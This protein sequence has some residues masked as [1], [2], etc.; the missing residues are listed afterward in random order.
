M[1]MAR[2]WRDFQ[3]KHL[4]LANIEEQY[5][6]LSAPTEF[7]AGKWIQFVESDKGNRGKE[8][9]QLEKTLHEVFL[10]AEG[11][12]IRRIIKTGVRDIAYDHTGQTTIMEYIKGILTKKAY[13]SFKISL[14]S[15]DNS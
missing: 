10:W 5:R 1:A 14:I 9:T 2:R 13:N 4:S 11:R 6:K 8:D 3:E 15:R 7:I 12:G